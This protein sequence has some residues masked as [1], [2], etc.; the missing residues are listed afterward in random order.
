VR[1]NLAAQ[2]VAFAA[3]GKMLRITIERKDDAVTVTAAGDE[4]EPIARTLSLPSTAR[5]PLTL[6]IRLTGTASR[7]DG[8]VLAAA[9]ARGPVS[10]PPVTPE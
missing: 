6:A 1:F 8:A 4:G 5:G 7:P 2:E 10:L 9:I 3:P